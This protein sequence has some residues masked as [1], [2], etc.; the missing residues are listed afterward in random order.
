[1]MLSYSNSVGTVGI[2]LPVTNLVEQFLSVGGCST[3]SIIM[4]NAIWGNP[5]PVLFLMEF[6]GLSKKNCSHKYT[7]LGERHSV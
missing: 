7:W 4:H 5:R 3:N 1:M 2:F 6:S